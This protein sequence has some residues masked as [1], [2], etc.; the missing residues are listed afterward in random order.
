M[1]GHDALLAALTEH[2]QETLGEINTREVETAEL[3]HAKSGAVEDLTHRAIERGPFVFTPVVI[4][5]IFE[6]LTNHDLGQLVRR[7]RRQQT[8]GGTHREVPAFNQP[9][10]VTSKRRSTTN[11]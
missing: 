5:E 8:R 4:Q 2:A 1:Q 10:K 6:L 7:A 9:R 11:N 3:G